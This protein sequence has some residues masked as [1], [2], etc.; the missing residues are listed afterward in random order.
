MKDIDN[1]YYK[2]LHISIAKKGCLFKYLSHRPVPSR[3]PLQ[4]WILSNSFRAEFCP[5]MRSFTQDTPYRTLSMQLNQ[6]I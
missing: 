3:T 4:P 1:A 6:H 5:L 2:L